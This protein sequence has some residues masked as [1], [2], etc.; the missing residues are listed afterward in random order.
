MV[1]W[2]PEDEGVDD[3]THLF[4]SGIGM[5]VDAIDEDSGF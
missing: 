5:L 4:G 3:L 2:V 1:E